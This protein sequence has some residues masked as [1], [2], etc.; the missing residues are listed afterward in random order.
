MSL[1]RFSHHPEFKEHNINHFFNRFFGEV[2]QV[3]EGFVPR[4]NILETEAQ[5]ELTLALPGFTKEDINIEREKNKL[6]VSGEKEWKKEGEGVK[7]HRVELDHGKFSRS[8][9]LPETIDLD[10]ISASLENGLLE[11]T[12]PKI[13]RDKLVSK[14][15]IK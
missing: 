14:V 13:S 7:Y 5:F 6:K 10:N 12:L 15:E 8:F 9:R 1:V 2:N 4:A 11:L 3:Q